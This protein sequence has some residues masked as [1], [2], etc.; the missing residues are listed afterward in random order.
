MT[1]CVDH[2]EQTQENTF[3]YLFWNGGRCVHALMCH[4]NDVIMIAMAS[5]ITSLTIVCSTVYSDADQRRHQSSAS[6]AFVRGIH[7]CPVN[8]P[9]KWPVTRKCFLLMTSSWYAIFFLG[10]V[11]ICTTRGGRML[12]H[13]QTYWRWV[14]VP[15]YVRKYRPVL[16]MQGSFSVCARPRRDDAT[17]LIDLAH[18]NMIPTNPTMHLSHRS[19][20]SGVLWDT[21][22]V[23]CETCK[24][25][26]RYNTTMHTR[27]FCPQV[28]YTYLYMK[29]SAPCCDYHWRHIDWN[30]SWEHDMTRYTWY[31]W[32]RLRVTDT[33][34]FL[35]EMS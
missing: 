33:V 22:Q 28:S 18:T 5:Q 34:A 31:T 11:R 20:L 30:N 10:N 9:H 2:W 25:V 13:V 27:D 12:R 29:Q 24:L 16:Q 32:P 17:S 1:L 19:V 7:R 21:G 14:L 26:Y 6:L 23:H 4:Y 8:S 15:S 35:N 3:K